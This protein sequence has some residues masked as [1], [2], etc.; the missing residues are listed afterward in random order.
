[1]VACALRRLAARWLIVSVDPTNFPPAAYVPIS[2]AGESAPVE[3]DAGKTPEGQ[4]E[5][6]GGKFAVSSRAQPEGRRFAGGFATPGV[7][8]DR[9][10][11]E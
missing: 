2:G 10:V 7:D 8:A 3:I 11:L 5:F 4:V 6:R 1:M 9:A